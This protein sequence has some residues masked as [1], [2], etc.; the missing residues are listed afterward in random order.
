MILLRPVDKQ[1]RITQRFGENP[2]VYPL[3][4]GHNGID[5]GLPEGN[6]VLAAADG[7]VTRAEL[8]T[9][10]A[11]NPKRGYGYN[12]RI[13]HADGSTTIYAH[14]Q[15]DSFTVATGDNVTMGTM[16]GRS[17]N[18]GFST[19]PHLHFELRLGVS[20]TS[21]VDPMPF[22]V[23]EIPSSDILFRVTVAPEGEGVRLRRGPGRDFGIVRN[24]HTDDAF[25][26][27]GIAG[28]NAWL[29]VKEG[30][31]M[32]DPKWYK[33]EKPGDGG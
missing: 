23:D 20:A 28:D 18:T 4:N 8:D 29:R 25:E 32:Y 13:Q 7:V 11:V 2:D 14:F 24:L 16:V 10:T 26:V 5:F 22:L 6:P 21:A 17:G 19:G 30:Y 31:I 27:L 15:K 9:E 33:I 1:F 3:T 12:V